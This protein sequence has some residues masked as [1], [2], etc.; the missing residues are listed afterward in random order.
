MS[1]ELSL[2][3]TQISSILSGITTIQTYLNEDVIPQSGFPAVTYQ[4]T[5]KTGEAY[6]NTHN[7]E[8]YIYTLKVWFE[9]ERVGKSEAVRITQDIVSDLLNSFQANITL[10]STVDFIRPMNAGAA[11]EFTHAHGVILMVPIE[12]VC[13]KLVAWA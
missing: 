7:R 3:D 11:Q 6:L 1:F 12:L 2:I 9:T 10:N 4:F 8:E 5:S 13:V